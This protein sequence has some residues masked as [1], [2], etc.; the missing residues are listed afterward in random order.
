ML[1]GAIQRTNA[2]NRDVPQSDSRAGDEELRVWA[3]V[4]FVGSRAGS[5]V[6]HELTAPFRALALNYAH[7]T[8]WHIAGFEADDATFAHLDIRAKPIGAEHSSRGIKGDRGRD[9]TVEI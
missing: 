5:Y 3:G 4:N 2:G 1:T 9:G 7:A 8:G 6:L